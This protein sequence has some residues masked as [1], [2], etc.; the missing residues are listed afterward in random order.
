VMLR[1]QDRGCTVFFS[2]HI[3]SDAEALCS[4]VAI[5]AHGRLMAQGKL[6]DVIAFE[7]RGWEVVVAKL[8]EPARA[9]IRGR[10]T[11][12][13]PLS[14]DRYTLEFPASE[15]P[16]QLIY[17][18]SMHGADVVSLNPLRATLEDYFVAAVGEAPP[19]AGTARDA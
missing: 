12:I 16:E 19:R 7:E 11:S 3:L 17:D 5:L 2:S 18:L 8:A 9:A 1:L 10:V 6:A 13:T 14:H 15:S 4:R